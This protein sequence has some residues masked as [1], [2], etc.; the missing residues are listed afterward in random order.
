[1]GKKVQFSPVKLRKRIE[2]AKR[3]IL[4]DDSSLETI[5]KDLR[6]TINS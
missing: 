6:Y 3:Q 5:L 1:M 2:V 4:Q